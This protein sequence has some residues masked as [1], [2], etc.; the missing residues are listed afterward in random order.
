VFGAFQEITYKAPV[1]YAAGI[2]FLT[3]DA[4]KTVEDDGV[5]YAPLNSALPFT[6]SGTFSGDD[7]ARFYPVQDKNKVIRVTSVAESLSGLGA[8]DGQTF[9]VSGYFSGSFAFADPS[10]WGGG[11]FVY[12][13]A[14][15]KSDHDG[16]LVVSPTVPA[17]SSQAGTNT[18]DKVAAFQN[19]DGE[20]DGG[21]SG[22]FVRVNLVE[23]TS[24]MCGARSLRTIDQSTLLTNGIAAAASSVGRFKFQD[25]EFFLAGAGISSDGIKLPS[26]TL[27]NGLKIYGNGRNKSVIKVDS[28]AR[29]GLSI[30]TGSGDAGTNPETDNSRNIEMYDFTMV[31]EVASAGFEEQFHLMTLSAVSDCDVH[32]VA[33]KGYRGDGLYI[34]S[35]TSGGVERHNQRVHIHLCEFDG[36]NKDNR[37]GITVI[38]GDGVYIYQN[39]FKNS[40]RSDMPGPIDVEPNPDAFAVTN[41]IHVYENTFENCGGQS[42]IIGFLLYGGQT[43]APSDFYIHN[44]VDL[45]GNTSPQSF[46]FVV[47]DSATPFLVNDT[48]MAMN[49]NVYENKMTDN[50]A[51]Q[52]CR[53]F[54]VHDNQLSG[55]LSLGKPTTITEL[56][57]LLGRVNNNI[58]LGGGNVNGIIQVA[59]ASQISITGNKFL[60]PGSTFRAIRVFGGG[61]TTESSDITIKDNSFDDGFSEAISVFSHTLDIASTI[62]GGNRLF[63]GTLVDIPSGFDGYKDPYNEL[64]VTLIGS[65]DSTKLPDSFIVGV[66]TALVNDDAGV[67]DTNLQGLLT[68]KKLS[69]SSSYRKFTVQYFESANNSGDIGDVYIRKGET[70]T[71]AWSVWYL[72]T[73]TVA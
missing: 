39:N 31:G 8:I 7:D 47:R 70:A 67:P 51:I 43:T 13:A 71:N 25:G 24:A 26:G 21:G 35:S 53:D 40:S 5:I 48:T 9:H 29:F 49:V 33:F 17:V 14:T 45:A 56:N 38:D 55:I 60:T 27:T 34:G 41:N 59:E 63:N 4:N 72:L 20:T 6:T 46:F 15:A 50:I 52:G 30:N 28:T 42:G 57:V 2:S 3:T 54:S 66:E 36:V 22:C 16:I 69:G 73:S 62:I 11:P 10:T 19:A 37:N 23:V 61:V 32:H 44:N 65:Y 18:E 68:T 64:S 1:A 12:S 58:F